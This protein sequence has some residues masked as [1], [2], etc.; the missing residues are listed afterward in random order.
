ML[1]R[2]LPE[3]R[4]PPDETGGTM[5][6]ALPFRQKAMVKIARKLPESCQNVARKMPDSH[7]KVMRKS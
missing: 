2:N 5:T 1:S 3:F 7:E 6:M 4:Y